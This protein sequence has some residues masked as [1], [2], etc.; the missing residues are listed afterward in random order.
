[1]DPKIMLIL[2][3]RSTALAAELAGRPQQAAA[4]RALADS[5]Q[6]GRAVDAHMAEVAEKL[7]DGGSAT[8]ADWADVYARIDADR[9]RLHGG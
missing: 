2:T 1:M 4:L 9:A 3:L 6:A 8:E 5:I 7:K